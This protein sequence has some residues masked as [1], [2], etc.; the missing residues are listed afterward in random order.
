MRRRSQAQARLGKGLDDSDPSSINPKEGKSMPAPQR[1]RLHSH[2]SPMLNTRRCSLTGSTWLAVYFVL[3]LTLTLYN[4]VV[5]NHFPFPYTLTALHALCGTIGTFT[6]LHW[7][8]VTKCVVARFKR[9]AS[10]DD[11]TIINHPRRSDAQGSLM[12]PIPK[13]RGKELVVLL[14]YSCLYSVNIAISN[15]S[16]RLVTV[17]VSPLTYNVINASSNIGPD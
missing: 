5:L 13:L 6:L 9:I 11:D 2:K 17:P 8:P 16:L 3:N 15:V 12:P 4:K 7:N 1:L 10:L 14:L